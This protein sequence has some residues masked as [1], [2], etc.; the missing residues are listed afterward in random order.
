[1]A[2]INRFGMNS[3]STPLLFHI[4]KKVYELGCVVSEEKPD[5]ILMTESRCNSSI[6]DSFLSIDGYELQTDLRMDRIDTSQGRGGV[7]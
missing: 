1:M 7:S 2:A 5:L 6:F 4:V 3:K